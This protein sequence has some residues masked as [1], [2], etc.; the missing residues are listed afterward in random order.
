M[1]RDAPPRLAT[2]ILQWILPARFR[3]A[4][5]GDLVEEYAV[6]IETSPRASAARWFWSQAF[7]SIPTALSS[8]LRNLGWLRSV[9]VALAVYAVLGT[10]EF[11]ADFAITRVIVAS[12]SAA[13][14]L[15]PVV[16]LM[17]S[18]IAGCVAAR[19]RRGAVV[20]V[21][22]FV[23]I[24]VSALIRLK[25]CPIPV[26]WWYQFGFLILGP[27]AVLT[28]PSLLPAGQKADFH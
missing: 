8:S 25:V 21:A 16:F 9:G 18:S 11:V 27:L 19:I 6:R 7:R 26:P 22:L 12:Q 14:A 10:V 4:A 24:T 3:E 28:A 1:R 15:A 17:A 20:F 5:L 23:V 13:I 2:A